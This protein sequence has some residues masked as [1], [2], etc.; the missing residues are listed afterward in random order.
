MNLSREEALFA[1]ALEKPAEKRP[2]FLDSVGEGDAAL[3]NG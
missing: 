1:M 3:R 2:L